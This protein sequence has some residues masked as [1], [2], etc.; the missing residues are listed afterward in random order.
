MLQGKDEVAGVAERGGEVLPALQR[1]AP[2]LT[3]QQLHK[4]TEHHHD[5][6]AVGESA[7]QE[8]ELWPVSRKMSSVPNSA[9]AAGYGGALSCMHRQCSALGPASGN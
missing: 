6:W 7:R 5:D 1:A 4:L 3:L 9:A 2:G 8:L